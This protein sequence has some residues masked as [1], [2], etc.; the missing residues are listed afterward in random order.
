[1]VNAYAEER[2]ARAWRDLAQGLAS[3]RIWSL[4]ALN[5]IRQRYRRSRFGQFWI[6]ISMA[7]FVT[8]IGFVYSTLFRTPLAEFVPFLA[9]NY[10]VWFLISGIVTESTTA[11]IQAEAYLRQ[12]A[13]PKTIFVMRMLLR[14]FIAFGH[15]VLIVPF[16]FLFFATPPSWAALLALPGLVLI[17]VAGFLVGLVSAI[18]SARFRDLP[19]IVINFLQVLFFVTPIVW[20]PEQLQG[21]HR[22]VVDLNPFAAFLRVVS[23]PLLG[24]V[25]PASTY[26]TAGLSILVLAAIAWPLFTRYRGRIVYWL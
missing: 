23:E 8:A 15:N 4:L 20:R 25:P 26:L 14:N 16:V 10:V 17:A 21:E 12:E 19:Q 1:M 3:W 13:L 2:N 11:F 24:R 5:D 6:T 22:L 7:I 9:A 18:L